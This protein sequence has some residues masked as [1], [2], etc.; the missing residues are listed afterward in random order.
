MSVLTITR[1]LFARHLA[2]YGSEAVWK[3]RTPGVP[4]TPDSDRSAAYGRRDPVTESNWQATFADPHLWTQETLPLI[5]DVP[6][7]LMVSSIGNLLDGESSAYCAHD[8]GVRAGDMMLL[9]GIY[10]SVSSSKLPSPEVYREL[11]LKRLS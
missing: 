5:M 4:V 10:Y 8:K 11:T 7:S 6:Q 3:R 9:D 2:T 1:N